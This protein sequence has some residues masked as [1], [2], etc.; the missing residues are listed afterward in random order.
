MKRLE[1]G[2]IRDLLHPA[3]TIEA[4]INVVKACENNGWK[5]A[6]TKAG[7]VPLADVHKALVMMQ[8]F[9]DEVPKYES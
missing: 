5:T 9:A 4:A 2:D 6:W 3:R 1:G 7:S 8:K